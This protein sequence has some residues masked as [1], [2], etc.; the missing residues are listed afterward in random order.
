MAVILVVDDD[1]SIRVGLQQMLVQADYTVYSAATG[2][3]ALDLLG[4]SL[5]L[6][7]L[8]LTLPDVDGLVVCQRVRQLPY[9][10][11]L[12][13]LTA[14]DEVSDKVT[15]LDLGAD[16]Y[17]T[18]PF[19]P[20]ELLSRVRAMLRFAEL[21][22]GSLGVNEAEKPLV[23]GSL[24]LWLKSH[25]VALN[26]QFIEL[27]TTEWSLLELFA[28]HPGQVFGRETLLNRVWGVDYY[29]DSRTVDTHIQRLRTKLEIDPAKPRFIQTVRG[30]GYRFA[31]ESELSVRS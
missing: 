22:Q 10:V 4:N 7:I 3:E 20:R 24:Q 13:M 28:T 31:T 23:L 6:I 21:R 11:P 15:G 12:M 18:K 25:R 17:L 19:E 27:T 9:Y 2:K 30:F 8:D 5:D 26:G 29:G 16:E 1:A 14:R